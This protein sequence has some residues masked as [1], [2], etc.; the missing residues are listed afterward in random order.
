[1]VC[2]H[3]NTA[4]HPLTCPPVEPRREAMQAFFESVEI[5]KKNIVSIRDATKGIIEINQ[6]LVLS[7]TEEKEE[8]ASQGLQQLIQSGN[9][10]AKTAQGLLKELNKQVKD[11]EEA[12]GPPSP[13]LRI[14][15][16]LVQT[17]TKKYI[18]VLKEYQN[19]QNKSKEVKK[20]RAV[21]RVQQ[22]KPDATAEEIDAVIQSGG[23]GE[24]MKQA[25]LQ[26]R[27][28]IDMKI[29][30]HSPLTLISICLVLFVGRCRRRDQECL[31][32]RVQQ[33]PR[34]AEAGGVG[35]RA[36]SD[37]PGLCLDGG[38]PGRVAGP[39]RVP[40][41]DGL[42]LHRRGQRAHDRGNRDPE[43]HQAE[44]VLLRHRSHPTLP[45]HRGYHSGCAGLT[46]SH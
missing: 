18:D 29:T 28:A 12:K 22:V 24:I 30:I 36:G 39:D 33:V 44:A 37:V 21:K 9:K 7:T 25:I 40:G 17:L 46:W 20:K 32:E 15:K 42:G 10:N 3:S 27:V 13:E 31:R 11:L 43:V 8:S 26:V 23:A 35:G 19:V 1:M 5:V 38:A 45:H 16:N 34:C 14:R 4:D 6:E 41:E 2:V